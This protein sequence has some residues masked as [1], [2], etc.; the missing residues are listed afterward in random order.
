MAVGQLLLLDSLVDGLHQVLQVREEMGVGQVLMG[1]H[2]LAIDPNVELA[3]LAGDQGEGLDVGA[4][5]GEHVARHPGGPQRM[6][7]M[8]TVLNLY[9]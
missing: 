3:V 7:S 6:A 8:L 4:H 2:E 5:P 9:P 1:G